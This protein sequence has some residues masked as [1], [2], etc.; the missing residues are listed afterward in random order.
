MYLGFQRPVQVQPT[1]RT[2]TG[3]FFPSPPASNKMPPECSI[4]GLFSSKGY[5]EAWGWMGARAE[6]LKSGFPKSLLHS[7][8]AKEKSSYSLQIFR[9]ATFVSFERENGEGERTRCKKGGEVTKEG[10]KRGLGIA[11]KFRGPTGLRGEIPQRL[12]LRASF[13]SDRNRSCRSLGM[14][15]CSRVQ[16]FCSAGRCRRAVS[17]PASAWI[18]H[19]LP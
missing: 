14:G 5:R 10:I 7:R 3:S 11:F 13:R 1:N 6:V 2:R 15:S 19:A 9:G 16:L 4:Y 12:G 17:E 8:S 18:P